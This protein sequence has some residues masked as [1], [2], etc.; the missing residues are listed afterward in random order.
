MSFGSRIIGGVGTGTPFS[1]PFSA[2]ASSA[3]LT[4][5]SSSGLNDWESSYVFLPSSLNAS[6][7]WVRRCFNASAG[8]CGLLNLVLSLTAITGQ[9]VPAESPSSSHGRGK[10]T[11]SS[12]F[13]GRGIAFV[14]FSGVRTACSPSGPLTMTHQ[15]S[16]LATHPKRCRGCL[17][18]SSTASCRC[19]A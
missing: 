1:L 5:F 17:C 12:P 11:N 2:S 10:T 8:S 14:A 19:R 13:L 18:V 15:I 3:S 4:S 9:V 16:V 7:F 6:C